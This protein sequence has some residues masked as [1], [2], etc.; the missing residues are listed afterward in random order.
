MAPKIS[1]A[2]AHTAAFTQGDAPAAKGAAR[3]R[4]CLRAGNEY[5]SAIGDGLFHNRKSECLLAQSLAADPS[6]SARL[7]TAKN[8]VDYGQQ[9]HGPQHCHNKTG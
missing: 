7:A 5:F 9:R 6:A 4:G 3:E 8:K 1:D 2:A